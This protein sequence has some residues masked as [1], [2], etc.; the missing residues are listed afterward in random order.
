VSVQAAQLVWLTLAAYAAVGVLVAIGLMLGGLRRVDATAAAAAWYVK[1][2]LV[3]G[4]VALWP[5][6]ARRLMGRRPA[7]DRA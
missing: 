2:L 3:P 6:M 4:I 5:I 1:V 7:E